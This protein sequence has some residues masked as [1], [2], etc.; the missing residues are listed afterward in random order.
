MKHLSTHWSS[1][2]GVLTALICL[3]SSSSAS[4][5]AHYVSDEEQAAALKKN[6][7]HKADIDPWRLLDMALQ[8]AYGFSN[9]VRIFDDGLY[10]YVQANGIPNHSTGQFP[11][12]GNP[13]T[14]SEQQYQFR[15]PLNP[16]YGKLTTPLT[17]SPFGVAVNGVPFD[18]YANEFWNRDHSSG[19]QYEAMYL[20]P[21]LGIDQNNAHVQPNGAYHYHGIPTG[22]MQRLGGLNRP[23][24]IGYAADGFP[25]Y[26]PFGY[27]DPNNAHSPVVKLRSS[28]RVKHGTR[29][30]GPGGAYT[31]EFVQDYEYVE[32]HGDLDDCNGRRGV[33]PEY[34]RATYYYVITDAYPYIPRGFK[35]I[36]DSTFLRG[37]R[38]SGRSGRGPG[39]GGGGMNQ[40][41]P[42]GFPGGNGGPPGGGFPGGNG[43]PPGGGFPGGNGGPPGGGFPGGN[44]GPPGGGFPG[45]NG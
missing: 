35:G 7:H 10:R 41:G 27:R 14:I 11:G 32:H 4:V 13:N 29:P 21:R 28:F 17:M 25:I 3:F 2:C 6:A 31:G 38:A 30:S 22:L 43:G 5:Q 33:T 15:M 8:P 9:S 39:G 18:P 12:P 40:G 45:G 44:G 16:T 34:P 37:P 20:G 19:W 24:L 1:P 26:G 36:P 23:L 42:G